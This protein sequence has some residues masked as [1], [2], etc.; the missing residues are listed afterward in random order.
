MKA[1][2]KITFK[3]EDFDL[4]HIIEAKKEGGI[5]SPYAALN[6]AMDVIPDSAEI[7]EKPYEIHITVE[8]EE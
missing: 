7:S 6:T 8:R 4:E 3:S 2:L 1:R 5:T